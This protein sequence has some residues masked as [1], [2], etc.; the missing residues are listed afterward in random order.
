MSDFIRISR[1]QVRKFLV[2]IESFS[3]GT[4]VVFCRRLRCFFTNSRHVLLEK[5]VD[6]YKCIGSVGQIKTFD[7][8][9]T[10]EFFQHL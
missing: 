5:D 9:D 2:T 8:L 10:S 3:E 6:K 1:L 4:F 7:E